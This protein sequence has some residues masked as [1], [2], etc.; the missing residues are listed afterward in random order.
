[1]IFAAGLGTR[2]KPFTLSKPKALV[3]INGVPLIEICIKR[4][5]RFGFDEIIIN[6]HHF[7]NQI[8]DFLSKKNNFGISISISNES[9]L[10]LD[11]GGGLKKASSFF[12]DGKPFLLHNVDI[13]SNINLKDF[14]TY[15]LKS[16]CLAT[17]ACMERVSNR[18]F[19][20]NSKNELCGWKNNKSGELKISR[21]KESF[22]KPISFC[23]IH[24]ISQELLSLITEEGVFSLVDVYLRLATLHSIKVLPFNSAVWLD[25]G[26]PETLDK[27]CKLN[28]EK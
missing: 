26:T 4:L 27:A 15:H 5:I 20:V 24:V 6:V 22:L 12:N 21:E 18:Q 13:V 7:S 23:G 1:M 14:Y 2:L 28:L 17:L 10:L 8:I 19:L 3:E 9:D 25:L 11:T 16:N